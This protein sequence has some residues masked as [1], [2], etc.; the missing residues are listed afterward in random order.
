MQRRDFLKIAG[1]SAAALATP[2]GVTAGD[3][4][5][6]THIITLSFDDGFKQS[7]IRTAEIFEKHKLSA[8]IN[9]IATAHRKDFQ[10][11]EGELKD[12]PRGDFALWN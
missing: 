11:P 2:L 3:K 6:K 5:K 1:A 4:G 8:C 7:S 12:W 9:V 10:L